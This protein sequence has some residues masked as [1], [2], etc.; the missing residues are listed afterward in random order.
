MSISKAVLGILRNNPNAT[1]TPKTLQYEALKRDI[2]LSYE[3]AKKI[4]QRYGSRVS[5]GQ[6]IF[7]IQRD[8]MLH[9]RGQKGTNFRGMLHLSRESVEL[10]NSENRCNKGTCYKSEGYIPL[11]RRMLAVLT[12]ESMRSRTIS[13]QDFLRGPYLYGIGN[14]ETKRI[15]FYRLRDL[16]VLQRI[17]RGRYKVN[18]DR[19]RELMEE[20]TP[21][22]VHVRKEG[23]DVRKGDNLITI[24]HH[25]RIKKPIPIREDE[26]GII[27]KYLWS[28]EPIKDYVNGIYLE[29]YPTGERD[30]SH[31]LKIKTLGATFYITYS[32]KKGIAKVM[33]YPKRKEVWEFY[34]EKLFGKEFVDRAIRIGIS[35]HFGFNL[36][37]I[38][39][40]L[41]EGEEIKITINKSDFGSSGD[42]EF[43]GVSEEGGELAKK[44]IENKLEL[45]GK[46]VDEYEILRRRL[47]EISANLYFQQS[48]KDV[49]ELREKIKELERNVR[50]IKDHVVLHTRF[51][52]LML[53]DYPNFGGEVEGYA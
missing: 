53:K 17:G 13:P 4:L 48:S 6:Y 42:L 47:D 27:S 1:W 50:E 29:A 34:A 26:L 37:E 49:D 21:L 14:A 33:I 5:R 24:S 11:F 7:S 44:L 23:T 15:Y 8:S 43:E 32:Y 18:V 9:S 3:N 45:V 38:S 20:G 40:V 25:F 46:I 31:G 22:G 16:G 52:N 35:S 36:D 2:P 39:K 10:R 19:A 12:G 41:W 28:K 51:I 30:R